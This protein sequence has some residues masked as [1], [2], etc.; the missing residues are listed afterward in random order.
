[1]LFKNTIQSSTLELL[2]ELQ[3]SPALN[4]FHL[5]GDTSLAL[6]IGHRRSIDLD[7]FSQ[8]DF[9]TNTIL[10]FLELNFDFQLDYSS[11]NT[12][13]GSIRQVKIDL[14]S[15]K[16]PWVKK[17]TEI[18][19]IRLFSI[20]DIAAMKLNAIAGN[21]TRSKDF[22]DIYFILKSYSVKEILDFYETKYKTRNL[23]HVVK[24]L[25]YFDEINIQDWPEMILE[26]ELTLSKVK[27]EI[28]EKV[29]QFME[30][31]NTNQ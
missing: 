2:R 27:T 26:K 5:A 15:H 23:F 11:V 14:I 24:S 8:Y 17:Y 18:E 28:Q 4:S 29:S 21:G 3:S 12:L 1:M 10:E 6:Q 25:I 9:D 20:P 30:Q 22:I 31:I 16:Y 19:N 13:K 7:L